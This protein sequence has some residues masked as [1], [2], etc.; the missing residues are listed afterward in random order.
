VATAASLPAGKYFNGAENVG[1]LVHGHRRR[2][3]GPLEQALGLGIA[4]GSLGL[5]DHMQRQGNAIAGPAECLLLVGSETGGKF[6]GEQPKFETPKEQ[7][8]L[9][10]ARIGLPKIRPPTI[11]IA[12]GFEC[13]GG[14]L[15]GLR[16]GLDG[17][18][19]N[20][21]HGAEFG[22]LKEKPECLILIALRDRVFP[23]LKPCGN[24]GV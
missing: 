16:A 24:L 12:I 2:R 21:D 3:L 20:E 6:E 8:N 10:P 19:M 13:A 9:Q 23:L 5:L 17:F 18:I 4:R 15:H 1:Q 14:N 22:L 7:G 11:A